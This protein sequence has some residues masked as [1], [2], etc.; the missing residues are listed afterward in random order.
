MNPTLRAQTPDLVV[1]VHGLWMTGA[2][3]ALLA[4]R[5][6]RRGC[7]VA[8]FS[9]RSVR[10]PL[11]ENAQRLRAF[12]RAHSFARVD[13]V[14]HSLGGLVILHMLAGDPLPGRTGRVV[15][16]G[17]PCNGCAAAAQLARSALG[18]LVVGRAMPGWR[19]SEAEAVARRVPVAMI[20]GT[21]RLGLGALIVRLE[22]PDDGVVRVQET[23][24]P[25]LADHR[26]LPVSHS[27]MLFSPAI[28][29]EVMAFLG[30]GRFSGTRA[31]EASS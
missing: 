16:L 10:S 25:G 11:D 29:G 22:P 21:R 2:A 17:T 15:L 8:T 28:A 24:F 23:R 6:R 19:G 18:R 30:T 26:V 4:R 3:C 20:A 27:G 1:I 13:F 12:V 31:G 7:R 9:Y 5:L 14:G